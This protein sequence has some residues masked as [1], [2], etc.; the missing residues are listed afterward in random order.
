M[1]KIKAFWL[2]CEKFKVKL[3]D[4]HQVGIELQHETFSLSGGPWTKELQ[5]PSLVH[6]N[7]WMDKPGP[8]PAGWVQQGALSF[9]AEKQKFYLGDEWSPLQR[10]FQAKAR[11]SSFHWFHQHVHFWHTQEIETCFWHDFNHAFCQ[12]VRTHK[13]NSPVL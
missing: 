12:Q 10:H 9:S 6:V 5:C 3:Q 8:Y 13:D 7:F 11:A 2:K 4:L 1:I